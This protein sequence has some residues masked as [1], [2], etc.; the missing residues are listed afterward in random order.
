M[1]QFIQL[2]HISVAELV[3]KYLELEGVTHVF[4]IPGGYISPFLELLRE[5]PTIKLIIARHEEGAAFMADGYARSTGKLGVVFTTAGP[6]ATNALTGIACARVDHSPVMIIVGQPSTAI[7]GCGAWQDSSYSGINVC[8]IF[9]HVCGFSEVAMH[10]ENFPSLFA[11]ALRVAHGT[12]KQTVHISIPINISATKISKM[13]FPL[14]RNYMFPAVGLGYRSN[15]EMLLKIFEIIIQAKNPVMLIGGGCI[16]ALRKP[17]ILALFSYFVSK[18]KIPVMTTPKAKGLFPESHQFSLGVFGLGG[19]L[20]SELYLHQYPPDIVVVLGSSLNEW[21]TSQWNHHL[22]PSN[23]MIQVDIDASHIGRVYPVHYGL[24]CD[25]ETLIHQLIEIDKKNTS[26]SNQSS[27]QENRLACFKKE[28][29]N[30]LNVD[31]MNSNSIPLKPQKVFNELSH[32]ARD[33]EI[34]FFLDIGNSTGF[35]SHYMQLGL[36]HLLYTAYGFTCMGW[37]SGAAIGAKLASPQLTC[38]AV[39]G[40][41]AF[42]MNGVEIQTAARYGVG[43]IYIIMFDDCY[44]MVNHGMNAVSKRA[45]T[46]KDYYS[47]GTPDLVKF[48]ESLGANSYLIDKPNQLSHCLTLANQNA[49]IFKKPQVLIVNI[50]P[51][52]Q[53]PFGSRYKA[54]QKA[55]EQENVE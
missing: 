7:S 45:Y 11:R 29:T 52:E 34:A 40:D 10:A 17:S 24:Q 48:S 13:E 51:Y 46:D 39:L 26:I 41:G 18:H 27:H 49:I 8:E 19:S 47:L 37:S 21:A 55:I 54:I 25:V 1:S 35:F 2:E 50:D 20:H 44:G 22:K 33:K 30:F 5:H 31:K 38:I 36:S 53:A 42:L 9:R 3:I 4:G 15:E 32:F 12:P 14:K 28:T 43:V 23:A 16:E 6:G